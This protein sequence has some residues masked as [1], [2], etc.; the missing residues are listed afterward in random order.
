MPQAGY[1]SISH[2]VPQ[3]NDKSLFK[4]KAYINGKWVSAKSGKTF[5][6]TDPASGKA[7]GTMPEMNRND[8]EM[9]IQAAA[10][11]L[12]AFRKTT[13]RERSRMLRRWW[14]LVLDNV[15]DLARLM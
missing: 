10:D 3:L 4:E 5:E 15:D 13:A 14:Q 12:P 7:I 6:V 2:T 11:A 9:A 1:A 8:T